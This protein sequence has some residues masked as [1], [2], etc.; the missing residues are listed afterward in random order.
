MTRGIHYFSTELKTKIDVIPRSCFK[1]A[2]AICP[3][4]LGQK[5]KLMTKV[6]GVNLETNLCYVTRVHS[7]LA[8]TTLNYVCLN[9]GDL[10]FFY[11]FNHYKYLS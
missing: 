7:V 10:K 11:I 9:H 8:L 5:E 2:Q 1:F 6:Q 3:F 4:F